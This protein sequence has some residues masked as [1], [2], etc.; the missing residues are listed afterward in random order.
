MYPRSWAL[1]NVTIPAGTINALG[2]KLAFISSKT[3][4][5]SAPVAFETIEATCRL[6]TSHTAN[7]APCCVRPLNL[8]PL[9]G[10]P[11][12]SGLASYKFA[13]A[14]DLIPSLPKLLQSEKAE[15]NFPHAPSLKPNTA[16]E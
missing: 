11:G 15:P 13:V 14:G 7:R 1:L 9:L 3:A 4:L 5:A 2:I 12:S 8:L 10:I 16:E 6:A